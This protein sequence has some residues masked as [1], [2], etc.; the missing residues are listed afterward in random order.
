MKPEIR[1]TAAAKMV[2]IDLNGVIGVPESVQFDNPDDKVATYERFERSLHEIESISADRVVVNIRSTGG[3]VGDALLIYDALS[4]L[5]TEV[6][7][8][9]YGYVASAATVI[10]Q[11]ASKGCREISSN[12]LYLIHC[13]ESAC[14]GNSQSLS[15]TKELLEQSD[16]KIAEIYAAASG[17]A[18]Q[19][20][21]ELMNCN[22]GKGRWLSPKEAL[23]AGLVDTIVAAEP[24][25]DDAAELVAQAGLPPLPRRTLRERI[26]DR[27]Q[28]ILS[29]LADSVPAQNNTATRSV[30]VANAA[31]G[32]EFASA[33]ARPSAAMLAARPTTT[34]S[35]EDPSIGEQRRS[36]NRTAY[37]SDVENLRQQQ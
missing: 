16:G 23:A 29:L 34:K 10:A 28:S 2:T 18:A 24:I 26:I 8:R 22:G 5:S 21:R 7:T 33:A 11:A 20:F 30:A 13:C 1:I 6:T 12:A 19:E 37:D 31:S 27:L 15:A 9:C 3:D 25:T 14:E 4:T 17:R 35:C 36:A 32:G